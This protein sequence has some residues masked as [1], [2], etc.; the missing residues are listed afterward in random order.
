MITRQCLECGDEFKTW[1]SRIKQGKG[2]FCSKSCSMKNRK[3]RE[4]KE[5]HERARNN[6]LD[7][8]DNL[9]YLVGLITSDGNLD[10]V[11]P[12]IKFSNTDKE[13]VEQASNVVEDLLDVGSNK[14]S[15]TDNSKSDAFGDSIV[16]SYSFTSRRLY[17]FLNSV[18]LRAPK[19]DNLG[20]LDVPKKYFT[21]FLRGEIDG[22]GS[23][24]EVSRRE[25]LK[26]G[27]YS[28]SEEFLQWISQ[29]LK[30]FNLV[31]GKASVLKNHKK[32]WRISLG[33]YDAVSLAET[34]YEGAEYYLG[35]KYDIVKDFASV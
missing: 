30:R 16:Y 28:K 2:K 25:S 12:R 32:Y 8:S 11:N 34:I 15:E 4:N 10:R 22:D 27:I 29:K 13:L 33:H 20:V 5:K 23:W 18:G 9:A 21:E 35:Y 14:I 1:E 3:R 19:N 26:L 31:D 7:W 6:P 17:Y 24:W